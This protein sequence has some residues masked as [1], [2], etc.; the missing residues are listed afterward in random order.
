M[1]A[2]G[3]RTEH[4]LQLYAFM[5]DK[6]PPFSSLYLTD[7]E[8]QELKAYFPEFRRYEEQC[9][10]QGCRHIHEPDCGVKAALAEHEISQLRYEDYL[11]LYNELKEKRRF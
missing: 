10:F 8:E 11:G 2:P 1:A 5:E 4:G 3:N 7:I 9:R 6:F